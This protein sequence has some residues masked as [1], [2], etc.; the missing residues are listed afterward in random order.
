MTADRTP[1]PPVPKCPW[2]VVQ[3]ETPFRHWCVD[4]LLTAAEAADAYDAVGDCWA[5]RQLW[6]DYNNALEKKS[7]SVAA[8][9]APGLASLF[10][11]WC[12]PGFLKELQHQL[13]ISIK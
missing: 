6:C 13:G 1:R 7:A 11:W 10:R 2:K 5:E 12:Q 8:A 3:H 4:G 9:S